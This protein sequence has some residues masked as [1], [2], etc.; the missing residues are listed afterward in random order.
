MSSSILSILFECHR[1]RTQYNSNNYNI[2]VHSFWC[3]MCQKTFK[4]YKLKS[5]ESSNKYAHRHTHTH[6]NLIYLSLLRGIAWCSFPF[7][8]I[9]V[10]FTTI[11]LFVSVFDDDLRANL[12]HSTA[13]I[14][15]HKNTLCTQNWDTITTVFANTSERVQR[16]KHKLCIYSYR[17]HGKYVLYIYTT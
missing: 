7:S 10:L 14:I 2:R 8:S 4:L 1:F 17:L 5:I 6:T 15:Q 13:S 16:Y 11:F 12:L 3:Y 9:T